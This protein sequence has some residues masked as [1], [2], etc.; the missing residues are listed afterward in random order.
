[1]TRPY[2]PKTHTCPGCLARIHGPNKDQ[3]RKPCTQLSKGLKLCTLCKE[4]DKNGRI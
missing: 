1:M 2:K 3:P 4:E